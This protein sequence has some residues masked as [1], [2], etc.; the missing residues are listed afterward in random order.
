MNIPEE[1][2]RFARFRT[3]C[4]IDCKLVDSEQS[5]EGICNNISGSGI[6][7]STKQA[8]E[9][10]RAVEI[11]V[12]PANRLIPPFIAFVEIVRCAHLRLGD[13]LI[14]GAIKGIKSE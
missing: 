9:L 5:F 1:N 12:E 4:K 2:R 11:R 14:A 10:G 6:L 13:Y 7:F 8:L 3:D